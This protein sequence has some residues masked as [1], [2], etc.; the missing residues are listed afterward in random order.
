MQRFVQT[1]RL[2]DDPQSI[3]AYRRA[4]DEIWPEITAGIKSV[5]IETM[6]IY[7]NGNL[8]V[9]IVEMPDD[10]DFASAMS[11]LATLPRQQ[12]WE[13]F[14]GKW[15]VCDPGSTSAGKWKPMEQI[16]AL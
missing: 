2:V 10:V 3:A 7:I 8:L 1:L 4:H 11:R 14:V 6:D 12:E 15:Q 9:M 13:E 5:G 16:F